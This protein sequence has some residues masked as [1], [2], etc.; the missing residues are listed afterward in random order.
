[1]LV[2]DLKAHRLQITRG[3]LAENFEVAFDLALYTLCV[4]LLEHYDYRSRPLDLRGTE[5]QPRSSL[6]DL[7]GTGAD[8]WLTTEHQVLE[9]DWLKLPPAEGFAVLASLPDGEKQRL[10]AW[11]VAATLKPQLA[12]EDRADPAIEAAGRR[13][14][15]GFEDYWRPTAAN[16]WA[17]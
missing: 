8:R 10:F 14:S 4:D 15:I 11:C 17:A 3:Y 2:D 1:M 6:N 13:L 12:I 5:T 16:Y 9:L 7:A